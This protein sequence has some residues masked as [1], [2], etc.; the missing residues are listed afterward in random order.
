MHAAATITVSAIAA[1]RHGQRRSGLKR[2]HLPLRNAIVGFACQRA[3]ERMP[4]TLPVTQL[5]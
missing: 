3:F 4:R 1:M 5:K 2:L